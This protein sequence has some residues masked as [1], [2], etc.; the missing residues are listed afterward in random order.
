[1]K[2]I[3]W[4]VAGAVVAFALAVAI[5]ATFVDVEGLRGPLLEAASQ[6]LGRQVEL[7]ALDLDLLP[8]PA[9]RARELRIAGAKPGD[10][11]FALVEELR[12]RLALLPLLARRVVLRA[13]EVDSPQL[14][15]PLD[16][17][18]APVLPGPA[19][20]AA[21]DSTARAPA[22]ERGAEAKGKTMGV[23]LAVDRIA[24]ENASAR[25]GSWHVVKARVGGSLRLDGS[26]DID[27]DADLPG[28][29]EIRDGR[30]S[31]RGLLGDAPEIDASLRIDADLAGVADR[32]ELAPG[33]KLVG[34]ARGP[35][36]VRIRAGEVV[37]A[38]ARL[39]L[40]GLEVRSGTVAANGE[41]RIEA[42]L[43][44]S[45]S[46]VLDGLAVAMGE[47][48]RKPVGRR[49]RLS[50]ELGTK[51]S[52]ESLGP[53]AVALGDTNL[54][55]R[56]IAK[57]LGVSIEPAEIDLASVASALVLPVE[58]LSGRVRVRKLDARFE[59]LALD[60]ALE[61]DAVSAKL[62]AGLV[63]I[64]GPVRAVGT[65]ILFD[66]L[67]VVF[68]EQPMAVSGSYDLAAERLAVDAAVPQ[69][70]LGALVVALTGKR[71]ISGALRAEASISGP[72]D[73]A[74]LTGR[75]RFS[76]EPGRIQG[77][78]LMKQVLGPLSAVPVLFAAAKGRD[79]S[80]YEQEEFERLSADFTLADGRIA[81]EN[82]VL[83]YRG[84]TA[85][86]KGHVGLVDRALAL[87]GR[88]E[89][90]REV[91]AELGKTS[92][93]RTV[94]PIAAIGGTIDAPRVRIDPEV[95]AS[96]AIDYSA[97]DRVREKID[98]RL[99]GRL[100]E[101]L[102]PGGA[103]AVRDVLQGILGGGRRTERSGA[104]PPAEAPPAEAPAVEVPDASVEP[105]EEPVAEPP[106]EQP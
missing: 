74:A 80:R 7:G 19:P 6:Q 98:E 58:G 36:S 33:A 65:Q 66:D 14:V 8:L 40:S 81:T 18:G 48:V 17:T 39:D 88:V 93:R 31:I 24:V 47:Q 101:K 50:G 46:A 97:S 62:E 37:A 91:D 41:A 75:G 67:S 32:I 68:A 3:L 52:L 85:Y 34:R 78:S 106:A 12:L 9:V 20:S 5:A 13:V 100:E 45:W 11:P 53:I 4:I 94:I 72:I 44:G 87:S 77:F 1:M 79:L 70:E 102:G 54:R 26:A 86:L 21:T 61:L 92:T 99:G 42:K 103:E 76:V 38:E 25:V 51:P 2:R 55:L 83:A 73:V 90:A 69:A 15:I 28:V 95:L 56:P 89:I 35:V 57:P 29:G 104:A 49:L 105:I 84:G 23:L 22:A 64:S 60:G 16:A 96:A 63:T 71:Q 82:L 10:E 43:G 30:A 59:P 27:L